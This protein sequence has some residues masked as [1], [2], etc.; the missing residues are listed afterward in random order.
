MIHGSILIQADEKKENIIVEGAQA[1]YL[2][3][4]HG[5]YPYVTSSNCNASGTASGAGIGPTKID[6]VIGVMKAYSSRVGEGPFTTEQN[7][8]IGDTIREIGH[9]YGTTT[10][11]PR[12]CRMA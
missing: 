6:E 2:D 5:D 8:E 12:R 3:L 10:K 9:E 1:L 11:R 4:D 7:N